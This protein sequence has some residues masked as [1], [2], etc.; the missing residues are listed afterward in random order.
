MN[1]L[2]EQLNATIRQSSPPVFQMLSRL[3]KEL[4]FPKG[5]LSQTAEAAKKATR[6]N[7]TIG[8]ATEGGSAMHLRAVMKQ[9]AAFSPDEVLTY[10]PACGLPQLRS[11]WR[12]AMYEKNPSLQ[13]KTVSLPL[14]TSGI[15][16]GHT[17]AADLFVGPGDIVLVPEMFWGNYRLILAVRHGATLEQYPL[18]SEA[19]RFDTEGFRKAILAQASRGKAIVLLN[20]PNNPTG[21]S[22]TEPE[23]AAIRE[24]LVE[25]AES[26]CNVVV[27]CD[28]AYF[29]LAYED[30]VLR[31]SVFAGLAAAHPRLLAVKLDGASKE[32][33]VWGLRLGFVTFA[34]PGMTEAAYQALESKGTGDIRGNISNCSRLSQAVM[35]KAMN[36]EGYEREKREKLE[37]MRR[38]AA[39]VKEALAQERFAAAWTPYPFNSGYF[40]CL[41]LKNIDAETF[42]ARLL[43]EYGIG[44]VAIGSRN[45]RVAF[46][47]VEEG[48]IPQLFDLMF[49]C[50][51]NLAQHSKS[52]GTETS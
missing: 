30:N 19:G 20:F 36:D 12:N 39:T 8:I 34:A 10:A 46:S 26:G 40:M 51:Q 16:H 50:A 27:I 28:D 44:V 15:T 45:I 17:L 22:V 43:D 11:R 41:R 32:D 31:E 37:V 33:Y 29:G 13:G 3:G 25:L 49:T 24:A 47:S 6:Y 5:I 18:F 21:Y 2:A 35:L 48:D 23:A 7:A 1:P 14:V 52:P 4:Y 9:C 38:R 42:R